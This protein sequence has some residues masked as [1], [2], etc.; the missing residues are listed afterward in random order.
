MRKRIFEIIE[1]A[2]PGDKISNIYDIFMIFVIVMSL[3]PLAFKEATPALIVIDLIAAAVFIIDYLLRWMTADYKFNNSSAISFIKYPFSVMAIIDL[4]SIL[5]S[6]S[7]LN[8]GFKVL[9]V[10]RMTRALRVIRIFKAFRYSESLRLVARTLSRCKDSLVA[11]AG[12][13]VGYM[14]VS[15][16]VIFN[17]EP[18]T[19]NTFYD[20]VYWS[21]VSL[22]TIGYGDITPATEI[23]KIIT[24]IS[25]VI[26]IAVIA[27]PSGIITASLLDV[28]KSTKHE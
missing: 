7:M 16:L 5:P 9:R 23:G 11:V 13:A 20:A 22:T 12:L 15:A 18:D 2:K 28:V 19:F 4:L 1:D 8:S 24:V 26:G 14:L 10:I 25:S 27:L 3:V 6:V 21:A 17:V